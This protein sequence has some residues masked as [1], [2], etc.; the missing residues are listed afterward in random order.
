MTSPARLRR[1]LSQPVVAELVAGGVQ[2]F[3]HAVAEDDDGVAGVELDRLLRVR[4][5]L[6]QA[7]DRAA[8]LEPPDAGLADDDRRVVAGVAVRQRAV[9]AA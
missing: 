3:G 5:E 2:R 8:L 4:R 7:D 6:E 9:G 1:R